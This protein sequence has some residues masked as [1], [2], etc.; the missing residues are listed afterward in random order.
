MGG[1]PSFTR[2]KGPEE[3]EQIKNDEEYANQ[4]SM[5]T[6]EM[7]ESQSVPNA[8]LS[9]PQ[10]HDC[11]SFAQRV[12]GAQ[13]T[14]NP[15]NVPLHSQQPMYQ[16]ENTR[17]RSQRP[18]YQ[19]EKIRLQSRQPNY[20]Y[21]LQVQEPS[22]QSESLNLP[23]P[24]RKYQTDNVSLQPEAPHYQS[25]GDHLES[26]NQV[27]ESETVPL[28]SRQPVY[29]PESG[30]LRSHPV[31][32]QP[33]SVGLESQ[34]SRY[35]S[36]TTLLPFRQ[37]DREPEHT[38]QSQ[39]SP[40]QSAA[41]SSY[42]IA[43][44]MNADNDR[45]IRE[46]NKGLGFGIESRVPQINSGEDLF[47]ASA[48]LASVQPATLL[49]GST[50]T[51]GPSLPERP[52][53]PTFGSSG[54][55]SHKR[56]ADI[57]SLNAAWSKR[58]EPSSPR[59]SKAICDQCQSERPDVTYCP[60][61]CFHFCR[62]HWDAQILHRR[63]R[64]FNGIP[65][66]RTDPRL[67]KRI[68]SIIEPSISPEEQNR[69]HQQDE[70]TTW[71][72]VLP[73][74]T[75]PGQLLFHDFGRYEEFLVQSTFAPKSAQFPSLI[76]FVGPTGAG[77]STIVKGLVKLVVSG[78]DIS[79]Q[80]TPVVG[81]VQHQAVPTSGEVHLYW[82][83]S[84]L[85]SD[86]PLM[87]AD[88]EG[89]GGGSREPMAARA[90]ATKE[91]KTLTKERRH[92]NQSKQGSSARTSVFRQSYASMSPR[93]TPMPS[94]SGPPIPG[95]ADFDRSITTPSYS[96]YSSYPPAVEQNEPQDGWT[97]GSDKAFRGVTR[98]IAWAQERDCRSR[99]YIVENLYPRI[100]YTFSDIVI[101]VMRNPK[102]VASTPKCVGPAD[103]CY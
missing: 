14:R 22:Y 11:S 16:S 9:R 91:R 81:L 15:Q 82:D 100:L 30:P 76:S 42:P 41:A 21:P 65:H 92:S 47:T 12:N 63:P 85:D 74:A 3:L 97:P 99:Q 57:W 75:C 93:N 59:E 89:L 101:L 98:T 36:K 83:L 43:P 34:Q 18:A 49:E 35:Q 50:D 90:T 79:T 52:R 102:S 37:R 94:I 4:R 60:A 5:D 86:R 7:D 2:Y 88:C 66:E 53:A 26:Q 55:H 96:P 103:M 77:K 27:Y 19:D 6:A 80:Q 8:E 61:C 95:F 69:L 67:A 73:D 39:V 31:D 64:D 13:S 62:E 10:P 46:Y 23:S 32:Y 56:S 24:R 38:T 84:S 78:R 58:N 20:S 68:R 17:L 28:P 40:Y 70:D 87:Y 45:L 72:G 54:G 33:E 71:F 25:E 44:S 29:Q 51:T 1:E 48:T